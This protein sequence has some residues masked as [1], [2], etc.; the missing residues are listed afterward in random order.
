MPKLN[1]ESVRAFIA[2][3]LP[4]W[5]KTELSTLPQR[6]GVDRLTWLRWVSPESVHLTLKFLGDVS[7]DKIGEIT[8]AIRDASAGISHFELRA[9]GLGVF[10]NLKRIN[11]VWMGLAGRLETII[12]LQQQIEENLTILGFPAEEHQFTP[13][14]TLARV[15]FQPPPAELQQFSQLLSGTSFEYPTPMSVNK[16]SLMRSQLSPRG[17]IYSKLI[18]IPLK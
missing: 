11:V 3:E 6:L 8:D 4:D 7:V 9:Q 15:R 10:P 13:H 18:E 17:A 12:Q 16:I 5:L 2:I 14:L 1:S